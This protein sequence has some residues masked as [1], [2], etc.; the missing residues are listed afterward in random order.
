MNDFMARFS[1]ISLFLIL[2]LGV[3]ILIKAS[4]NNDWVGYVIGGVAVVV[5]VG[6]ISIA[7][8]QS[9]KSLKATV[10]ND[11]DKNIGHFE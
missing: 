5:S 7:I 9:D 6:I 3:F 10:K 1:V 4:F 8:H 11:L 2:I